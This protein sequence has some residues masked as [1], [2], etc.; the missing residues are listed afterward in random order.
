MTFQELHRMTDGFSE[1]RLIGKGQYGIVYKVYSYYD[2][3]ELT[4]LDYT[5]NCDAS[6]RQTK[7]QLYS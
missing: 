4:F 6:S 3:L 7:N 1:K 2:Q 5:T